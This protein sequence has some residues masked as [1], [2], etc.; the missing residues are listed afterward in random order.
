[1]RKSIL[2]L[3]GFL[4]S[5]LS[6]VKAQEVT[7][8]VSMP[9]KA[10][11]GEKI[12]V[13]VTIH[14]GDYTDFARFRQLLPGGFDVH[15]VETS[16]SDFTLKNGEL[17][18]IWLK[19]P[20]DPVV[21]LKYELLPDARLRGVYEITGVFSYIRDQEREEM[22]LPVLSL[23][24][25]P[26]GGGEETSGTA[27]TGFDRSALPPGP[28]A[29][30]GVPVRDPAGDGWIIRLIVYRDTLQRL[31]RLEEVVPAGYLPENIQGH[32]A[33]FSYRNGVVKYIWM[34]F[35]A[36]SVFE[37]SY[38]LVPLEGTPASVAPQ[39]TGT[40]SYMHDDESKRQ[41]VRP[42]GVEVP[43]APSRATLYALIARSHPVTPVPSV[44][45]TAAAST[46]TQVPS[47]KPAT[48]EEP[49]PSPPKPAEHT[50]ENKPGQPT[51]IVEKAPE[52]R[53]GIYFR[54]QILATTR[55]V[56]A[57]KYFREHNVPGK[58]YKEYDGGLYKYTTG[59]FT[60]Y[61]DARAFIERLR[62]TTDIKNA[63]VTAYDGDR[64]ITVREALDRT[65]QKW[66]K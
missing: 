44:P 3:S 7:V 39:I 66:F 63:F 64:R 10:V 65:G 60:A 38:K 1:M 57:E 4:L 28:A 20:Q 14:K 45:E 32:G 49:R 6:F 46:T 56:E 35:P 16:N 62:A 24:L 55:P 34:K 17:N 41:E 58:I 40:F 59:R 61:R 53:E 11:A 48:V 2:L 43:P 51:E 15:P 47:P 27:T 31:G 19:L 52:G 25:L 23:E 21:T 36:D 26:P 30:R 42:L 50:S 9:G 13:T 54:V 29:F 37:V 33:I 18:F 5:L 8:D 12:P 22:E